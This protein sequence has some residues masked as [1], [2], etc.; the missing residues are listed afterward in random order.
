MN[1]YLRASII[2]LFLALVVLTIWIIEGCQ[3]YTVTGVCRHEA[4]YAI[5]VMGEH[6]PVRVAA[7]PSSIGTHARAQAYLDGNWWWL[8]VDYPDVYPCAGDLGFRPIYY[9]TPRV[10]LGAE[11]GMLKGNK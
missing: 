3:S 4:T 5:S 6:H 8:C 11:A 10:W 1:P 2:C 9:Y 7:G